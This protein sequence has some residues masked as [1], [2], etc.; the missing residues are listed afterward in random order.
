MGELIVETKLLDSLYNVQTFPLI[1][2]HS[3]FG[4]KGLIY[5]IGQADCLF[6]HLYKEENYDG[7]AQEKEDP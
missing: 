5:K 1:K 3:C 2:K 6:L 7:K 4:E